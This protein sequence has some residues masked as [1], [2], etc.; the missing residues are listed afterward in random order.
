M[1]TAIVNPP[2]A[3]TL[4]DRVE[5]EMMLGDG[6][7]PLTQVQVAKEID[8]SPSA[9]NQWLKGRYPGDNAAL[10]TKLSHWV[11]QREERRE[12]AKTLPVAPGWV[13]LPTAERILGALAYTHNAGDL[14]VIYGGA[15]LGKTTAAR[16]YRDQAPAV[17]VVTITPSS[18]SIAGTLERVAH[19]L[20]LGL[21][22]HSAP[23]K[24]E[25]AIVRKLEGTRGLLIVDEAQHLTVRPLEAL[26]SIHDATGIGMALLGNETIYT[27]LTGGHRTVEHA[28]LFS[29]VGKRVRLQK[30]TKGDVAALCDA[31][32]LKGEKERDLVAII[33]QKPG[34]LRGVTKALRIASLHASAKREPISAELITAAWK[35]LGGEL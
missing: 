26:R 35:E 8:I 7:E 22:S 32:K 10:E 27:R 11:R 19:E 21:P 28:Q 1:N 23:S 14:S 17:W 3:G 2:E 31:W 15:G 6:H 33:S 20:H 29:R 9:L 18:S 24:L 34:A 25:A 12:F 4:R 5:A 30:P 13:S 16:W